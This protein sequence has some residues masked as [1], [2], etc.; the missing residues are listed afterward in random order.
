MRYISTNITQDLAK[1]MVFISGPRQC[2]KT[3]MVKKL[4]R[5][6]Q[7]LYLN[8]DNTDHRKNI[9]N[10]DWDQNDKIIYFDEIHKFSRWKNL[11]KGIY[12][13]QQSQHQFIVTG[14][15]RLDIYKKGQ[16]SMMGRFFSWRLHPL[17]LSELKHIF[18]SVDK[19]NINKLL[20]LGAFPEPFFNGDL[21][22]SKRWRREK[23]NLVFRQ[24]IQEL[25]SIRDISIL[26]FFFT[27]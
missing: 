22:H 4:I 3:T 13:T 15:A 11:V 25:E 20:S 23:Q 27:L 17:C 19:E 10:G 8:W 2:G 5:K 26:E 21:Q 7:S 9:M 16:D 24:D 12:D 14:S 6:K 18:K 1:K